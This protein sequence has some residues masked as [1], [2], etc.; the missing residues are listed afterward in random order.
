MPFSQ[1]IYGLCDPNDA[2]KVRYVGRTNDVA[3]RLRTHSDWQLDCN[4]RSVWLTCLKSNGQPPEMKILEQREF[5]SE[6]DGECWAKEQE[7]L[8]IRRLI[9]EGAD[10]LNGNVFWKHASRK[11]V[12]RGVR[13]AWSILHETIAR[14]DFD[15][16]FRSDGDFHQITRYRLYCAIRALYSEYPGLHIAPLEYIA[17]K[18]GEEQRQEFVQQAREAQRTL[19]KFG[20][21]EGASEAKDN[22]KKVSELLSKGSVEQAYEIFCLLE[23]VRSYLEDA[24]A[25]N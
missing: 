12:P 11:D 3:T 5:L 18:L 14:I 13:E 4:P 23:K 9:Q 7:R 25:K 19:R 16:Q 21:I 22:L 1:F 24:A 2:D 15:L 20:N 17:G 10:L 6:K 8:W